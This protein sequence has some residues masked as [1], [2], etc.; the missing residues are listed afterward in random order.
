MFYSKILKINNIQ[1]C[2]F[3]KKNGVSS[4]IYE[5]LNCGIGSRD[6]KENVKKNLKIV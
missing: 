4:G 6:L 3:S 5:S 1:H 2:F